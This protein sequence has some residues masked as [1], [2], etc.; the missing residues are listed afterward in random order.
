MANNRQSDAVTP[1]AQATGA[2][3]VEFM[4]AHAVTAGGAGSVEEVQL[5]TD[6]VQS[7]RE[8]IVRYGI[9]TAA[10]IDDE[11][12]TRQIIAEMAETNAVITHRS[13]VAAWCR[14]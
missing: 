11:S 9:A 3:A 6:A 5:V 10:E 7:L 2:A 1:L 4:T 14:V 13:D 12:L 8:D